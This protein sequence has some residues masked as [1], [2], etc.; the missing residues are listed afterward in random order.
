[1][2]KLVVN[3]IY[4]SFVSSSLFSSY[5]GLEIG[6]AGAVVDFR[7]PQ[8]KLPED[9]NGTIFGFKSYSSSLLILSADVSFVSNPPLPPRPLPRPLPLPPPP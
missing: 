8:L 9:F 4:G 6:A 2:S 5:K 1:M 7:E 3:P